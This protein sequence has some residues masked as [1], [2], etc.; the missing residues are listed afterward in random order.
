MSR[1]LSGVFI[2]ALV[3]MIGVAA[4][5]QA[6]VVSD[7]VQVYYDFNAYTPGANPAGMPQGNDANEGSFADL[8]VNGYTAYAADLGGTNFV[9]HAPTGG[10]FGGAFYS[11]T[12]ATGGGSNGGSMAVAQDQAVGTFDD[13]SFTVSFWEKALF[14]STTNSWVP[15]GGRSLLFAKGPDQSAI[16]PGTREGYGLIFTQ[17]RFQFVSNGPPTDNYFQGS[18]AEQN[19]HGNWDNGQW[20]QYTMTATYDGANSEYDVQV[21][22]NGQPLGGQFAGLSI[23]ENQMEASGYFTIGSHWRGGSWPHQRF[24]SWHLRPDDVVDGEAWLD[25]MA[26]IGVDLTPG[27][28]AATVNLGNDAELAYDMGT[29]VGLLDVHR[30]GTGSVEVGDL[31]WSFARDLTGSDGDLTGDGT[32][33]TLVLDGQGGTGL[34][35]APASAAVPEPSTLI[36][37]A[38]GLLGLMLARRRRKRTA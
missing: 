16:T 38:L 15:G 32:S 24:M 11:Q 26:V 7:A 30:D 3:V 34:I 6:G 23:P 4:S 8:S 2:P 36:L 13:Q 25:D 21:Y 28:V 33:F 9:P 17:G 29:V 10:K 5:V 31:T 1:Q 19:P 37:A 12:P 20:A 18:G 27:E 22:V 35:G 14:R